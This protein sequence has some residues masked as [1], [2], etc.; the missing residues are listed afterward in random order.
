[1]FKKIKYLID[2]SYLIYYTS[3]SVFKT[4]IW[5]YNIKQ[6][7]LNENFDP[8]LDVKFCNLLQN[9]LKNNILNPIQLISPFFDKSDIIFCLDCPRKNIW[10]RDIFPQYKIS[11]DINTQ[12]KKFNI[13]NVFKYCYDIIL[14]ELCAEYNCKKIYCE[15]VQGDDIIA[16]LCN[17][18]KKQNKEQ[19]IV[20]LSADRDLVQL[21]N[22]N[23]Q[24]ITIDGK[25]RTPKQELETLLKKNIEQDISS[26]D[27][28]LFKI[29][30]GDISD[31]I[32]NIKNGI[33]PKRAY[34]LIKDQQL[35][36]KLLQQDKTIADSFLRNKKLI[37]F[38]EIPLHLNELVLEIYKQQQS[39]LN[40]K[41]NILF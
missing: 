31:D 9:K 30:V 15:Y 33:G 25:K 11:R 10:R 36:K 41:N 5:K 37:S 1:M 16:I 26:N 38:K 24:I 27:F 28:L 13:N 20:I 4:Y 22:Q 34:Q 35:L 19:K 7:D 32:P 12:Q 2:S 23:I 17:K 29:L 21:Y 40:E 3:F 18:Y 39:E 8:T 6:I 14:P